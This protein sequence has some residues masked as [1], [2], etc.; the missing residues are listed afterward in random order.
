MVPPSGLADTVTPPMALPSEDLTVPLNSASAKTGAAIR[1]A[2]AETL[3]KTRARAWRM[4][5]SVFLEIGVVRAGI[6]RSRRVA[7]SRNGLDIGGKRV[8]F[9]GLEMVLEARHVRRAVGN[10]VAYDV[11]LAA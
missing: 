2:A 3:A 5:Y 10:G 4:A 7:G 8:D 11:D 1:R 9:G 6:D